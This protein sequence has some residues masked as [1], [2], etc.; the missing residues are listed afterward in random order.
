MDMIT[1]LVNGATLSER[2]YGS[3]YIS[4]VGVSVVF[5][6]LFSLVAV[7]SILKYFD[8]KSMAKLAAKEEAA[9]G[10][11]GKEFVSASSS[12]GIDQ[13]ILVA[14]SAAVAAYC[15]GGLG[16]V[17]MPGLGNIGTTWSSQSR[18]INHSNHMPKI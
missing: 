2:F 1:N 13:K 17:V 16:G 3:L 15:S 4:A 18:V 14:I 10:S 8:Q 11:T 12:N 6:V 9:A 5:V 7:I